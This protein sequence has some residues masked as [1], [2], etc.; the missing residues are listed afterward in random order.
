MSDKTPWHLWVVGIMMLLWNSIGAA[1]FTMTHLY[2]DLW[3]E[4]YT[5]AQKEYF[6]NFPIWLNIAWACGVWGGFF[7]ALMILLKNKLALTLYFISLGGLLI[8]NIFHLF[9]AQSI[10]L[11]GGVGGIIFTG[12]LVMLAL[13]QIWYC[14]YMIAKSVLQ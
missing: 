14:K 7:A 4:Q 2:P 3:L 11:V 6:L 10:D 9:R 5:V 12:L 1:D 13:L 8:S